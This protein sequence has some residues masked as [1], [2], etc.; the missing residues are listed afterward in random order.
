VLKIRLAHGAEKLL[1][2]RLEFFE[3]RTLLAPSRQ[4]DSNL[5]RNF[6]EKSHHLMAD[7]TTIARVYRIGRLHAARRGQ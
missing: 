7:S 1:H 3:E 2:V 4:K 5:G 6:E